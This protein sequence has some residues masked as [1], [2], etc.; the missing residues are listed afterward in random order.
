[1]IRAAHTKLEIYLQGLSSAE[2]AL[3]CMECGQYFNTAAELCKHQHETGGIGC[4]PENFI[5]DDEVDN[6]APAPT[7]PTVA[8][9][10]GA[11][12]PRCGIDCKY[13][14][15]LQRHLERKTPCI[16]VVGQEDLSEEKKNLPHKCKY[17][18]RP[19]TTYVSMRRHIRTACKAAPAQTASNKNQEVP[20]KDN[21]NEQENESTVD[22]L[23]RRMDRLEATVD[24]LTANMEK[25]L[26]VLNNLM[27]NAK[28]E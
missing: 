9:N 6:E 1:M 17:C 25:M 8:T 7:P 5:C 10:T 4:F 18:G 26:I 12:C 15:Y 21:A 19:F 16:A 2:R 11:T 24:K 3:T 14:S 27:K 28:A 23:I 20:E 13:P 22:P